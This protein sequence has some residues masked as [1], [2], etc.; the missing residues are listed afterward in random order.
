MTDQREM[1]NCYLEK[2]VYY[3]LTNL[4]TGYDVP[5]IWYFSEEDF[6]LGISHQNVRDIY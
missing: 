3:G 4:N 2:H 5:S 1:K 6:A